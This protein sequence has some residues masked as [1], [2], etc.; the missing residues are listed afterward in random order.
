MCIRDRANS[1]IMELMEDSG[2]LHDAE[3]RKAYHRYT[4]QIGELA[5]NH[6]LASVMKYD[7]KCREEQAKDKLSWD[8]DF[9]MVPCSV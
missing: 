5:Q 3:E 6:T 1:R 7:N 2:E 4:Q 8:T 9:F